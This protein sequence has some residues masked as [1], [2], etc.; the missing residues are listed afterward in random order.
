MHRRHALQLMLATGVSLGA[1]ARAAFAEMAASIDQPVTISFY[2]YNL[3]SAGLGADA[4]NELIGNFEKS[5]PNVKVNPIGVASNDILA[6][7]Q[8]DILAGQQPDVAQLVFRDMIYIAEDLE[9]RHYDETSP[10]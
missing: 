1:L 5:N 7:I 8:A 3:A 10:R 9:T 4:T 6:R 2:D